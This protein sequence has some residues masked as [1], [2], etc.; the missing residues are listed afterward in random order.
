MTSEGKK[1]VCFVRTVEAEKTAALRELLAGED[2]AIVDAP[3]CVFKASKGK[4]TIAAYTSGKLVVQGR[5][6]ADTVEFLLEPRFFGAA[7]FTAAGT[8]APQDDETEELFRPHAGIDESGKGDFFGPLVAACVFVRSASAAKELRALGVRDS[9]LIKNDQKIQ[10]MAREIVRIVDGKAAVAAV[11]PEAYNRMYGNF[12]SLNHLLAWCHAHA[13]ENLLKKAPDCPAALAD[14]FGD[15]SLI[16]R[17][18]LDAGK[19][20]E[21]TQRT[22][23]ESDVAVAAASLLARAEFVRRLDLLSEAAG[24]TLP[25]GAGV[26]VDRVAAGLAAKGGAELLGKIAKMHFRTASR[27]LGLPEE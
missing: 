4:T 25:K 16:R 23:A 10:A 20:I 26:E 3:Y 11:G 12:R 18:L 15:E 17:A 19:K 1:P 7:A 24:V 8:A 27:A 13:L 22:K 9:K 14:K 6:A 2:W 21:L 5:E